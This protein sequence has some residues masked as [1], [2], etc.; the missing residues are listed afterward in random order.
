MH[1]NNINDGTVK[2][3]GYDHRDVNLVAIV[4]WVSIFAVFVIVSILIIQFIIYPFFTPDW[5]KLERDVPTFVTKTRTPPFPQVQADPKLDMEVFKAAEEPLHKGIE[6]AKET[7]AT[8]GIS[9]V[10]GASVK[11]EHHS[12]PGSG[13]Y[14]GTAAHGE[15]EH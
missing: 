3:L 2:E 11:E 15:G 14:K 9:G 7:L 8:R 12:Y 1:G 6:A 4:R 10:T 5:K 13:E